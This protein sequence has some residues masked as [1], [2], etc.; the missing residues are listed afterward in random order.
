MFP[1]KEITKKFNFTRFIGETGITKDEML[2]ITGLSVSG[3][4]KMLK[5]GTI[6]EVVVNKLRNHYSDVEKYYE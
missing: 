3:L 4:D 1:R 5:R 6:K 2:R